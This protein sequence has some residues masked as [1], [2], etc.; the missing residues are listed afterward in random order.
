MDFELFTKL[1]YS[2]EKPNGN[3][4]RFNFVPSLRFSLT[5]KPIHRLQ[6]FTGVMFDMKIKD[7]ND[8][9][10]DSDIFTNTFGA[11]SL[12]NSVQVIPSIRFGV[13][14]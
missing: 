7:F 10:F 14:F 13:R 8:G 12:G 6:F 9:A 4:K 2:I 11:F 5:L 1:V 3:D